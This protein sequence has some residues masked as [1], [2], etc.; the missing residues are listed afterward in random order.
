MDEFTKPFACTACS[1]R[2][3]S[4]DHL[5]VHQKK[6]DMMLNL[7]N[8]CKNDAFIVDQTPT[9]TRFI[10]NCEEVGLFQDLQHENPFDETFRRA[11][12]TGKNEIITQPKVDFSESLNTPVIPPPSAKVTKRTFTNVEIIPNDETVS[13]ENKVESKIDNF[14]NIGP[15]SNELVS[16]NTL[17]SK[18]CDTSLPSTNTTFRPVDNSEMQIIITTSDGTVLK[19]I[20]PPVVEVA[21]T[22]QNTVVNSVSDT[23]S[24]ADNLK[25]ISEK[26]DVE[27]LSIAKKKLKET[28]VRNGAVSNI[29]KNEI[30]TPKSNVV[31]VQRKKE[32]RT[33]DV[34][35]QAILERNRASSMRARAK[36][37]AWIEQLQSSLKKSNEV[38]ASLQAQVKSLQNQVEKLK[39]LLLA[40]KDCPLNIVEQEKIVNPIIVPVQT[41]NQ[42]KETPIVVLSSSPVKR[43]TTEAMD[44]TTKKPLTATK[45]PVILPKIK[46]NDNTITLHG[47]SGSASIP[48]VQLVAPIAT[49]PDSGNKIVGFLTA[50]NQKIALV[51]KNASQNVSASDVFKASD[52]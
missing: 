19:V 21:E 51:Q 32:K 20:T 43:P 44:S 45:V 25:K 49:V 29:K 52:P 42:I 3:V 13:T 35:K 7:D 22:S 40:H 15:S 10:R 4:E 24:K 46:S 9:P 48:N 14:E 33:V 41:T 31:L 38:N 1:M 2:F 18:T 26:N 8:S 36:R 16:S 34:K 27:K 5:A 30:I 47:A 28:L 11:V 50:G 23:I 39:S 17:I 12:E 37:K 6:H